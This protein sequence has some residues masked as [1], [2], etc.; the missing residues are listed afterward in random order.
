MNTHSQDEIVLDPDL[1]L[2]EV[3]VSYTMVVLAKNHNDAER[4]ARY[5]KSYEEPS[6]TSDR[7]KDLT[8]VDSEQRDAIP[9]QAGPAK[10]QIDLTVDEVFKCIQE[11]PTFVRQRLEAAGQTTIWSEDEL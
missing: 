1:D 10:N 8:F 5:N 2:Y 3:E 4:I 9:H 11:R 7:L 6:I